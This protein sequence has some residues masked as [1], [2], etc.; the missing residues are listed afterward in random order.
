MSIREKVASLGYEL[1][2]APQPAGTY[3]PALQVGTLVYVAGQLPLR[4]GEL[5]LTGKIGPDAHTVD[6]GAA[7]ARQCALN[8]LAAVDG[9]VGLDKVKRVVR[10]GAFVNSAPGFTAQPKVANGASD[11][12][13]EVFGDAGKHVR[14]AVGVNE[15]PLDAAV[16]IEFLFEVA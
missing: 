2:P 13:V 16:E 10:L 14:A 6:A 7:A 3:V 1:P 12:M 4:N 11:F 8:A 15:L 9:L 5:T